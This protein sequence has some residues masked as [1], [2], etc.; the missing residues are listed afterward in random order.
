MG[1]R[2]TRSL[3]GTEE[4]FHHFM[5]RYPDAVKIENAEVYWSDKDGAL[6]I[7]ASNEWRN[8]LIGKSI[9]IEEENDND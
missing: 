1:K 9:C 2:I 5:S 3:I 8:R 7:I 4:T 6:G